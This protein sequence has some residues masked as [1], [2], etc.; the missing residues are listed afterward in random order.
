MPGVLAVR[1]LR[2]AGWSAYS[3]ADLALMRH[4]C[5]VLFDVGLHILEGKW[6][7][8]DGGADL[9]SHDCSRPAL[10][11]WLDEASS[12]IQNTLLDHA[13]I[14]HFVP[15]IYWRT[16]KIERHHLTRANENT[17]YCVVKDA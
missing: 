16:S 14:M 9:C 8:T 10:Q 11:R 4:A 15:G 5:L 12:E 6:E 1:L 17:Y 3:S 7:C 13:L 2:Y